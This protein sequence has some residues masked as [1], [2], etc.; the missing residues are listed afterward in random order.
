MGDLS[1]N[2]SEHEFRYRC[3]C[4]RAEVNP[5]LVEALQELR[6]LAARPVWITS[7]YR[8]PDHSRA[9]GRKSRS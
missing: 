3:V 5:C 4:G 6:N 2:F 7:G 9:K 8:Y 1:H